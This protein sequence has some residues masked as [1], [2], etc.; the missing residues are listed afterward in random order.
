MKNGKTD[1]IF[2]VF[3]VFLYVCSMIFLNDFLLL[4]FL[5]FFLISLYFFDV[6]FQ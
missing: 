3:F 6:I 1:M 4:I 2:H 5:K